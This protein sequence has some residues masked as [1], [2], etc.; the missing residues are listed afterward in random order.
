M[1]AIAASSPQR[2]APRLNEKAAEHVWMKTGVAPWT[3]C[4]SVHASVGVF[5]KSCHNGHVQLWNSGSL[6]IWSVTELN[7]SHWESVPIRPVRQNRTCHQAD[8]QS[9]VGFRV[10]QNMGLFFSVPLFMPLKHPEFTAGWK[11]KK[12]RLN[13]FPALHTWLMV[14]TADRC[15]WTAFVRF[16][17]NGA[18]GRLCVYCHACRGWF[19]SFFERVWAWSRRKG[20]LMVLRAC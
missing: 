9:T 17:F 5:M 12:K 6:Q 4:L 11:W 2:E 20:L 3:G 19:D 7:R 18:Q 1:T 13:T 16:F 14:S 10:R 15:R 8:A